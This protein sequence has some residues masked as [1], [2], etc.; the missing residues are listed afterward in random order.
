MGDRGTKVSDATGGAVPVGRNARSAR[1]LCNAPPAPRAAPKRESPSLGLGA[2]AGAFSQAE[3]P[4]PAAVGPGLRPA[5]GGRN[6]KMKCDAEVPYF[7]QKHEMPDSRGGCCRQGDVGR[8]L[9]WPCPL[10]C[11]CCDAYGG[12]GSV[13]CWRALPPADPDVG[14]VEDF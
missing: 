9:P 1:L 10:S 7:F 13:P 8:G 2:L 11:P 3:T 4:V 12:Q 6:K 5:A 14:D